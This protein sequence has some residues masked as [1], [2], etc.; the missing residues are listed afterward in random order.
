[1]EHTN[2]IG[3]N[4]NYCSLVEVNQAIKAWSFSTR[5]VAPVYAGGLP[6]CCGVIK[7]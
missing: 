5:D 6:D 7:P 4:Q 1:M 3:S 2:T